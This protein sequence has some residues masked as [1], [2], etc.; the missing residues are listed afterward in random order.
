MHDPVVRQD[1]TPKHCNQKRRRAQAFIRDL[2]YRYFHF[3]FSARNHPDFS[4]STQAFRTAFTFLTSTTW[5]EL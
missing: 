2:R 5:P 1:Q 4:S 3:G